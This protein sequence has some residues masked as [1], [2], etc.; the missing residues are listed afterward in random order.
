MPASFPK[1]RAYLVI[2]VA[3]VL[4]SLGY[5]AASLKLPLGNLNRPGAGVFPVIVG[6]IMIVASAATVLEG[7]RMDPAIP[8]EVPVGS[9]GIRLLTGILLLFAAYLALPWLGQ[10]VTGFVFTVLFMRVMAGLSWLKL[11]IYSLVLSVAIDLLFELVLRVP[12]PR[13]VFGI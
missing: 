9:N 13:G 1:R 3:G 2:G 6:I 12:L 7:W 5:L 10:L 4:L 8:V 11:V